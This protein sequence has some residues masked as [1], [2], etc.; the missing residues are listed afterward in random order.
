MTE[1]NTAEKPAASS[2]ATAS[3]A[4]AGLEELAL[5]DVPSLEILVIDEIAGWIFSPENPGKDYH[6]EHAGAI[7]SLVLNAAQGASRFHPTQVPP[8]SD[9]MTLS[10]RRIA[11]GVHQIGVAPAAL[12]MFVITLMPA[13]ISELERR[14]GDPASQL[15]WLY[16]Y[17]LLVLAGGKTGELGSAEMIGIMASFDGWNDLMSA[18]YTLPWRFTAPT[19]T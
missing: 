13:V 1:P 2:P 17:S 6:G 15:Y 18:G 19:E 9:A 5:A 11:D 7:I 10:R 4:S 8:A 3:G 16:C 12:S 14:A